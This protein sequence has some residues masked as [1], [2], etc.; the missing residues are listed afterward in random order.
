MK[1][2]LLDYVRY[3][4]YCNEKF[5]EL[6]KQYDDDLIEKEII[7]SFSSIRNTLLHLWDAQTLWLSRL[8]GISPTE[9][10]SKNF[11]GNNAEVYQKLIDNSKQFLQFVENQPPQ[12]F[13]KKITFN[14]LSASGTFSHTAQDMIHH[15]MNHQSFHRGQLVTMARQLGIKQFPRTDFIIFKR[16]LDNK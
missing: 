7:S 14:I 13:K 8:N 1:Q 4:L 9:F 3:N 10:P 6:F 16:E 5:V 11:T 12:F 2:M 15:C